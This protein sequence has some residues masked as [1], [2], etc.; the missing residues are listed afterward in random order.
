[1]EISIGKGLHSHKSVTVNL[2]IGITKTVDRNQSK[3]CE[4]NLKIHQESVRQDWERINHN[5]PKAK[6][7]PAFFIGCHNTQIEL[8]LD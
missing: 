3:L 5:G 4:V 6:H 8:S 1:M 2:P 7:H